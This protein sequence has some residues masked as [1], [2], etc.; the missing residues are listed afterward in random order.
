MS[1]INLENNFVI[2]NKNMKKTKLLISL[3]IVAPVLAL[4]PPL[5][6]GYGNLSNTSEPERE[7]LPD[8]SN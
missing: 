4:V 7:Y 6:I 5:I 1:I 2:Y 3:T 8:G